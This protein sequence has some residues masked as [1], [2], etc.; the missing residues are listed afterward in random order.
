[1]VAEDEKEKPGGKPDAQPPAPATIDFGSTGTAI[2]LK[3]WDY[4][5]AQVRV[6]SATEERRY[7]ELHKTEV[8]DVSE[9]VVK[10]TEMQYAVPA[11]EKTAREKE[12]TKRFYGLVAILAADVLAIV[13]FPEVA[14]YLVTIGVALAG[15]EAIRQVKKRPEA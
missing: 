1:M 6:L 11:R 4:H 14:G 12:A 9:N 2:D 5:W 7:L 13:M 3:E 15:I 10:A 8:T